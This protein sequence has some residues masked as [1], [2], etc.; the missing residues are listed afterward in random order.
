M[1]V[2]FHSSIFFFAFLVISLA[3]DAQSDAIRNIE[4]KISGKEKEIDGLKAELEL[5]KLDFYKG[6]L[7]KWGLPEHSAEDDL[8]DHSLMVIQ[9]DEEKEQAKW[10]A[11]VLSP[12][13]IE[14]NLSRTN[15]FRV[16]EKVKTGTT[17]DEDYFLKTEVP[18]GD[19]KYDGY[20]FDRGHLA[21]SA[22]FRWSGTA[23]SESYFYSN[24]SPQLADFNRGTW[25]DLENNL[26]SYVFRNPESYLLV[27]TG[28]VFLQ[29]LKRVERSPNKVAIPDAFFK[30]A[31]DVNLQKGVAFLLPHYADLKSPENY[32]LS[33]DSLETLTGINFFPALE[34]GLEST[35]ESD[36]HF[37]NWIPE[38]DSG[39]AIPILATSLPRDHFNTSQATRY[40]E[41]G[42]TV[43]V[44]GTVVSSKKTSKGTVFL[45]LDKQFPDQVFT[46]T[47]W[48]DDMIHFSYDPS[49][50]FDGQ[51]ACFT[52]KVSNFDGVPS[53]NISK[54]KAIKLYP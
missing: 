13:I 1:K 12:G 14:G 18:G 17:S 7:M 19:A 38:L 32:C 5:S 48:K 33:I 30:V 39:D 23:M 9:Y 29:D 11:H 20:G 41:S 40:M 28:P 53:M 43:T 2:S 44:C 24:I 26:R 42:E 27:V 34:D 31:V 35:L 22:D 3:A 49:N 50:A 47:I 4:S 52:G 25:A 46:V 15:D 54:E 10:V 37:E 21:P 36:N 6:E 8:V 45:N 51:K 16:D